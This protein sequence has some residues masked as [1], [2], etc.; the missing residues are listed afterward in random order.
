VAYDTAT[1]IIN[2]AATLLGLD[3]VSSPYSSTSGH[4]IQLRTLL[5]SAGRDMVRDF[6]WPQLRTRYNFTTVAA[7]ASYTMPTDF[8]RWVNQTEWNTTS[9]IPLGGPLGPQG[10]E[11]LQ[12]FNLVGAVQMFFYTKGNA[13]YLTPTPQSAN[14]I[15]LQYVSDY[16]VQPDGRVLGPRASPPTET[17]RSC[18]TPR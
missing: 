15:A 7:V 14:A 9:S 3:A 6:E 17:T 13:I 16:W 11:L 4:I 5:K 10:W 1:T 12:V 2:D 8:N 18:S